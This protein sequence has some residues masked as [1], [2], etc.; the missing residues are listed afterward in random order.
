M[1]CE[2]CEVCGAQVQE[3]RRGRCWGCYAR[4][5]DAREVGIGASCCICIERRCDR[6]K[7]VELLGS[8]VA[9]CFN[10]AGRAQRLVPIPQT[11]LG[12]RK[13]LTRERRSNERRDGSY[14]KR[15]FQYER[16]QDQRRLDAEPVPVEDLVLSGDELAATLDALAARLSQSD[17]EEN[18]ELTQILGL[19]QALLHHA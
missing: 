4:W 2:V 12:L 11:L 16:R 18:D 3:L 7:S 19:P 17:S 5:T 10:C 6:L 9:M 14:D 15:V 13:A 1:N 8:W